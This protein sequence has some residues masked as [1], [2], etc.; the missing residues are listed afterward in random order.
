MTIGSPPGRDNRDRLDRCPE[1]QPGHNPEQPRLS[2]LCRDHLPAGPP[3]PAWIARPGTT[4]LVFRSFLIPCLGFVFVPWT[5]LMHAL[6]CANGPGI[7]G[8]VWLLLGLTLGMAVAMLGTTAAAN[9]DR[10]PDGVP[11]STQSPAAWGHGASRCS[12]H[13]GRG[14]THAG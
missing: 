4:D 6:L 8:L 2:G 11:G 7:S 3:D 1:G 5:T 12:L 14:S 9:R 10:L 13:A